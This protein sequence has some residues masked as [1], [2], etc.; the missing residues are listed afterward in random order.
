MATEKGFINK[1]PVMKKIIIFTD[2]DGTLLDY[3]TYSFE[4][5][6]TALNLIKQNKIPLIICSSKTRKEVE[7]YRK[8]LNN[9]HPFISENG[10]GIFIPRSY[11]EF[12]FRSSEFEVTDEN[13]YQCIR[14]GAK[15]SDLRKTIEE[16]RRE[17]FRVKGFGDMTIREISEET[18][19]SIH[20]A[21]M[22]KE[23]YFDEPFILDA[24]ETETMRLFAAI[25][26]KG[27][28]VTQ[29]RFFH[30]LGNSDKGKAVSILI[31]L[32]KKQLGK[33]LTVAIGDSSNDVPMLEKVGCPIIVQK[34]DG[35]Y[36]QRV[37]LLKLIKANGIGPDGWN[38][39]VLSLI[40]PEG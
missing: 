3:S 23:R 26:S 39:T 15:Y 36:D 33:I 8:K 38:R 19:L 29:G 32:Y 17:G 24:D 40:S 2:L 4:K 37:N 5:A 1:P 28:N 16:L 31:E 14:L 9:N 10:G 11:F 13:D 20:E 22:A 34:P 27:F 7:Y 18:K 25:K 35:A 6:L 30:I 12:E 21:E